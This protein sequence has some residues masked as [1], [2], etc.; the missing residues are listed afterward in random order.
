MT[1]IALKQICIICQLTVLLS[2]NDCSLLCLQVLGSDLSGVIENANGSQ[3][4]PGFFFCFLATL[5][6]SNCLML[7]PTT[8]N[9]C[10]ALQSFQIMV[11][12][13]SSSKGTGCLP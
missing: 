8:T 3:K 7:H 4:V 1:A 9:G 6:H 5:Q 12:I 2:I 13:C 10:F 11:Q